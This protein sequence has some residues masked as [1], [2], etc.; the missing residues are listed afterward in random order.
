VMSYGVN[1][2]RQ[3]ISVR[4]ALGAQRRDVLWLVVRQ[5]FALAAIGAAAGAVGALALG[6]TLSSL[7]F[8]V[9]AADAV[10]FAGALAVALGT[11]L[12]AC[13][14]PARRAA[15]LDSLEGLRAE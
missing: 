8:G 11:A 12:L 3:E 14:L 9:S 10:S 5:G 4:M 2:R 1:Q 13:L 15:A 7:L 6:R